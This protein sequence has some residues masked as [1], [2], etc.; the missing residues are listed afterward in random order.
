MAIYKRGKTYW[1][2]FQFN[3]ERIQESA[4]TR[5]KDVARQIEAAHRTRLA[6]GE[7]GIVE[8][9]PA[10]TL[11]EFS[12]EFLTQ[13]RMDCA[14][15][16]RTIKF[17]QSKLAH[18]LQSELVDCHLDQ[19][20]EDKV[21]AYKRARTVQ[22]SRRKKPVAP[23]QVNRELA[24]LRRLL[25]MARKWKRI[26]S[27]PEIRLL[28]GESVREF[29]LSPEDEPRY[30]D[31][32][33]A[34]MRGFCPFLVDTGLRVGEGIV[35]E[36]PQV[37]LREQPG[38]V[39][40]RAGTA[41]NSKKR[42]VELTPRARAI[43]EGLK[44]RGGLVF[45][46]ADGGPLYH[47]WLDQQHAEVRELLGFPEEFV[48]HS[49]RHTFGTRLGASG[50]DVRTI[51]ELMGHTSLAVAQKYIHPS[52]DAKRNAIARMAEASRVPAKVPTSLNN[53]KAK[54]RASG[55]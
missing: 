13:I 17:Y 5:N 16:P 38:Y 2:E 1:Y 8:R 47:T 30:F 18:I 20:D 52:T 32:L 22:V 28:R 10:P 36:W 48:L 55:L 49:L 43:L 40:V 12:E 37:N 33:P 25:R 54:K 3:G 31:A 53:V 39:T 26:T 51:M 41:K 29:V 35:L 34:S 11:G 24:T 42:S 19:I 27:V 46:N 45:R 4:H 44:G 21:E 6:K 50:A 14:S 7:A 9:T 23:A 15:K